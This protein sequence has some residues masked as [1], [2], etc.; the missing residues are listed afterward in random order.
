MIST[1]VVLESDKQSSAHSSNSILCSRNFFSTCCFS[2]GLILKKRSGCIK[3]EVANAV[4]SMLLLNSPFQ[5]K[6][7]SGENEEETSAIFSF[8]DKEAFSFHSSL[9][10]ANNS[11]GSFEH[12]NNPV[13]IL[14]RVGFS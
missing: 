2:F 7:C 6:I 5:G 3:C 1:F 11:F 8:T 14:W 12:R 9:K 10:C 13:I 4:A